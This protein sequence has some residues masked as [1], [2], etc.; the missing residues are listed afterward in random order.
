MRTRQWATVAALCL[1]TAAPAAAEIR[2]RE[3]TYKQGDTTLQGY[4][5]WDNA[6]ADRRPG[7][8]IVHEWWGHND[9]VRQQAVRLAEAGYIGFALDMYGKGKVATHPKDAEAFMNEVLKASLAG[10]R[11]DAALAQLKK[12]PHV[13]PLRI[14]AIGYCFGGGVALGMARGGADLKAVV[15]FHGAM[16]PP[17]AAPTPKGQVKA[18][19]LVL[20]GAAD[21][22]VP[23]A[24][25]EAF[26]ADL[27]ASGADVTVVSY[28]GVKHSF[29]NPDAA[30]YGMNGLA[31]DAK[32]DAA[33][34]AAAMTLL[35]QVFK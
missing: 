19:V 25:V 24:Q 33:S 29:T 14:A 5:A 1:S 18:R 31:Y 22:M 21:P 27:K 6:V 32:A 8:L 15:S 35:H 7:V 28:P 9:H 20:A 30:K 34:W 26:E 16:P 13:D 17:A 4:V 12:D 10:P 3:I 11:F 23:L 2:T